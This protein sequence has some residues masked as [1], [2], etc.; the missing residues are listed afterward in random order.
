LISAGVAWIGYEIYSNYKSH[1]V[2]SKKHEKG[3]KLPTPESEP[4][5]FNKKRGSQ[6]WENTET[7]EIYQKSHTSHG[8][9]NNEGTQWKVWPKGTTDFGPN[10]KKSG[11][12]TTLDQNGV[13][14]GN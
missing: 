9:K 6:G 10:S 7:G 1:T 14:I 8:N 2:N 4:G 12:R 3:D 5:K 13:V 11:E